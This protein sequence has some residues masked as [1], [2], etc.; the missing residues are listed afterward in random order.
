[1]TPRESE[2]SVSPV[3]IDPLTSLKPKIFPGVLTKPDRI[4]PGDEPSWLRILRNETEP[5]VNNWYC[6]KQPASQTLSL[7]ITW[8]DA[9]RQETE[10]FAIAQPWSSLDPRYQKFL[11]TGNLTERLSLILSELI[12]KRWVGM[13]DDDTCLIY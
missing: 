5:L 6:V 8:A 11:G 13:S 12:A 4:Q 10:F 2:P 1:M 7:G 3:S 9:R